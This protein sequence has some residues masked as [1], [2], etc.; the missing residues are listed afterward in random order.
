M[1]SK[2]LREINKINIENKLE[3]AKS[4]TDIILQSNDSLNGIPSFKEEIRKILIIL[5][6]SRGFTQHLY[7][8]AMSK[9]IILETINNYNNTEFISNDELLKLSNKINIAHCVVLE[10]LLT[11]TYGVQVSGEIDYTKEY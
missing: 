3:K 9:R 5:I 8:L 4:I 2:Y 10:C 7:H 11:T 1:D 6:D